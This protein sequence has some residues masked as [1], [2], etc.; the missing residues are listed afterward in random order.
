[1]NKRLKIKI[2][3][4]IR[5]TKKKVIN[6]ILLFVNKHCKFLVYALI[7]VLGLGCLIST[8]FLNGNWSNICCGIG[9]GILTSL[10]V[11]IIINA[12]NNAR[13][14]RKL[15]QEKRFIFNDIIVAS[16]DVYGDVVYRINEYITLSELDLKG[17]YHLY[18]D[19][20]PFNKFAEYLKSLNIKTL[21]ESEKKRL[22]K[23]F[24]LGNYRIDYLVSNLKHLPK[25]DY[26]LRGL[27]TEDE[28][29]S[30]VSQTANDSYIS[31]V[32]H[33]NDFWCDEVID[34]EKCIQFLRM[35]LIITSKTIATFDYA[36][37]KAKDIEHEIKTDIDQLYFDEIYSKS[38]EYALSLIEKD[39]AEA[40]Y[41]ST[42]PEEAEELE[43]WYNRTDEDWMIDD[44]Y[45]CIFGFSQ[46]GLSEILDKLDPQSEK[47]KV[48]FRQPEIC[49]TLKKKRKIRKIISSRYGKTYLDD[50]KKQ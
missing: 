45:N 23:L 18:S 47:V 36:A 41:Y 39:R 27:L 2:K 24:N 33:I 20:K 15:N 10:F 12:E 29:H 9:T 8:F 40:E 32:E 3:N 44:L 1:M 21:T 35:T 42:H 14:K 26:Y 30:I 38:E 5:K 28:Y 43:R 22:D 4:A 16:L 50:I 11:T 37:K 46:Q 31:Y 34:L 19:F 6:P 17:I 48:F 13:E 49:D 7:F 25:Q